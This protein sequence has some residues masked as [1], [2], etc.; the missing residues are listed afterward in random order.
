MRGTRYGDFSRLETEEARGYRAVLLQQGRVQL[1]AD[2]NVGVE[3]ARAELEISLRDLIGEGWAPAGDPG[4]HIGAVAPLEFAGHGAL[5]LAEHAAARELTPHAGTPQTVELRLTW[6]GGAGIVLDAGD[7]EGSPTLYRLEIGDDGVLVLTLAGD[8]P[9]VLRADTPLRRGEETHV[10][11][12]FDEGHATLLTGYRQLARHPLSPL[13]PASAARPASALV[14][15]GTLPAEAERGFKGLVAAV[16]IW[17]AQLSPMQLAAGLRGE[18]DANVDGETTLAWWRFERPGRHRLT[19]VVGGHRARPLGERPPRPRLV[20]LRIGAGRYYVGGVRCE[21]PEGIAYRGQPGAAPLPRRGRHLVYLEAWEETVCATQDPSLL[22]VALGGLDTS[23]RTRIATRVRVAEIQSDG[24]PAESET[25]RPPAGHAR[26][27]RLAARHEG[28]PIPANR[29]YRVE[30]HAGGAIPADP[31]P[32]WEIAI[33]E[34]DFERWELVLAEA[35][36]G[37]RSCPFEIVVGVDAA[38]GERSLHRHTVAGVH[39]DE[40][41][42]RLRLATDPS[43]LSR[44]GG[45]RVRGAAPAPTFKWSRSNGAELFAIV[46]TRGRT[47]TAEVLP[48]QWLTPLAAGDVVEPLG[49]QSPL[50]GPPP[51]L[52][53]VVD[54]PDETGAIRLSGKLPAGTRLLR[55]WDHS[56]HDD[57]EGAVAG[58][59]RWRELEDGISVQA[60]PGSY[61]RGD[62]W[63]IVARQELG[64]IEWPSDGGQP[65]ALAPAG[66]ERRTAPLALLR[67][68]RHGVEVEDLRTIGGAAAT[69]GVGRGVGRGV[70]HGPGGGQRGGV[71]D[72]E[73]AGTAFEGEE[74]GAPGGILDGGEGGGESGADRGEAVDETEGGDDEDWGPDAGRG[75]DFHAGHGRQTGH[76]GHTEPVTGELGESPG[77]RLLSTVDEPQTSLEALANTAE[78]LVLATPQ[79]LLALHPESGTIRRRLELPERRVGFSLH[80]LG[81]ALLL[82]GGRTHRERP[83]G[84]VIALDAGGGWRECARLPESREGVA[85]AVVDGVL[86]ALGGLGGGLFHSRGKGHHVYEAERD[87]WRRASPRLPSRMAHAAAV[88][89]DGRLCLLGGVER[90]GA[91]ASAVNRSLR[92]DGQSWRSEPAVPGPRH[93]LGACAHDGRIVALVEDRDG[94]RAPSTLVFDPTTA[95]WQALA[96]LPPTLA[97]PLLGEHRGR[98]LLAGRTPSGISLYESTLLGGGR[99]G[100]GR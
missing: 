28:A 64:S 71:D 27:G 50:D 85:L 59:H 68:G 8:R 35:W 32:E 56:P 74:G 29:L 88:A 41:G 20:D 76:G 100:H 13:E 6:T 62:Y 47:D 54:G 42:S 16:R 77:W 31:E 12:V 17:S 52:V 18:P 49:E 69:P 7:P 92:R 55:R 10:A 4:F 25:E 1:D 40:H 94:D 73:A 82:V 67:L 86:H 95:M 98:L 39:T 51:A 90:D 44:R 87:R 24:S 96:P 43:P 2:A 83:D 78:G 58:E 63:W 3:L 36:K 89:V 38:P 48:A 57:A 46:P 66:V 93:V 80:A 14:L 81:G 11:I 21:Q 72:G 99:H 15:G 33:V 61:R 9:V 34:I 79:E 84:R 45:L 91:T 65:Q 22:E 97:G 5:L 75:E 70:E 23:V 30:V 53:H 19:D 37:S 26:T 60:K